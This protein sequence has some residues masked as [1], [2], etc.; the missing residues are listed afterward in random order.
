MS[1]KNFKISEFQ[2][3]ATLLLKEFR[4]PFKITPKPGFLLTP[5]ETDVNLFREFAT[6]YI[7]LI[8]AIC[9]S[10]TKETVLSVI[11]KEALPI[12]DIG[13]K[14]D[15]LA[16]I[17]TGG[18]ILDLRNIAIQELSNKVNLK[19]NP[20]HLHKN[21]LSQLKA[22]STTWHYNTAVEAKLLSYLTAW[23]NYQLH[24]SNSL[25]NKEL[26]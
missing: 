3:N 11:Q 5:A 19:S 22:W 6:N 21:V 25:H 18:S 4:I 20:T 12:T 15:A 17:L 7:Y 16:L 14:P 13:L 10:P 24:P 1:K 26:T 2:R 8:A 9:T 23:G